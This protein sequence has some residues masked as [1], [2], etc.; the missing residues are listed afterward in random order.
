M[1]MHI[2]YYDKNEN[3]PG[4]LLTKL[5]Y[6]AANVNNIVVGSIGVITQS[7]IM[8][9]VAN[10]I[11]LYYEWR[12]DL[13]CLAFTPIM[14][15]TSFF[16]FKISQSDSLNSEASI[17][18]AGELLSECVCNTKTVYSYNFQAKAIY[19]YKKILQEP[20]KNLKKISLINGSLYGISQGIIYVPFCLSFYLGGVWIANGTTTFGNV[21]TTLFTFSMAMLYLG[22]AQKYIGDISSANQSLNNLMRIQEEVSLLD[23]FDQKPDALKPDIIMGKIEFKNVTFAYPTRDK[24]VLNNVSLEIF[25]GQVAAFVGAS[26]SGKST[27]IQLL[28]RFYDVKGDGHFLNGQILIDDVDIK[29]Y[30]INYLRKFISLVGQEPI[31]FKRSVRE[32]I[33]YGKFDAEDYEI[34]NA[35]D[36][37][38][39]SHLLDKDENGLPVSGGEKQRIAIARAIVRDPKII[40]LD[41]ATSALDKNTEMEIQKSLDQIMKNRTSVVVAHR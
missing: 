40:L 36:F 9:L 35:A 32:N 21:L 28:E 11:G 19:M 16:Y 37:S 22:M 24:I 31:L 2:G 12:L 4:S 33:M 26:G 15:F 30:D 18:E 14:F 1:R 20:Y 13:L 8:L 41:E 3:N 27:I 38:Q 5:A 34:N 17:Y 7:I 10:I 6:D 25:P 29:L 39:I 23:P